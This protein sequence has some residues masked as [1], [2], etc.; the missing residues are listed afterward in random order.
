MTLGLLFKIYLMTYM[1]DKK[2]YHTMLQMIEEVFLL[3][4]VLMKMR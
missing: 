1:T 2:S 4:I 3:Q